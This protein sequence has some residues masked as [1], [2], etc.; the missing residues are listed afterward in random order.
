MTLPPLPQLSLS[1]ILLTLT[2]CAGKSSPDGAQGSSGVP[3][4]ALTRARLRNLVDV[5]AAVPGIVVEL[6]YTTSDNVTRQPLY[7]KNMP[8]LLLASTAEKLRLAQEYLRAQG[9]GLKIWDGWRP[10]EVQSA[11]F[12]HGGYTGMFTDPG[13][14]WSRHCSGTAVDVTLVDAKGRE[15]KMPTRY[16]EGGPMSHYIAVVKDED[17]RKRR[18]ALQMAMMTA[19]FSVLDTEWWHFDDADFN[20][21]PV[22]PAVFAGEL[23]IALP[24]VK[25]P[26]VQRGGPVYKVQ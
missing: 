12:E 26:R 21:G 19:G 1:L 23:G 16:D 7:P 4:D 18:H 20:E 17:V 5:R 6:R 2:C 14:M 8:C 11:L 13:I 10:P 15:L 3:G 9:Y 24:P 22:P 25:P